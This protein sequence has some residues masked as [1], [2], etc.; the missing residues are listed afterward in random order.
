M[1]FGESPLSRG[2]VEEQ[3]SACVSLGFNLLAH[4]A[5]RG[6]AGPRAHHV[7]RPVL[8]P[9]RGVKQEVG[10]WLPQAALLVA[11]YTLRS[12]PL[13]L[14]DEARGGGGGAMPLSPCSRHQCLPGAD[15]AEH[16][17]WAAAVL[18]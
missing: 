8:E 10:S 11:I 17:C 4:R 7:H 16:P 3:K 14:R 6:A 13:Q 2:R 9:P 1:I 15:G 12:P 5:A 18:A